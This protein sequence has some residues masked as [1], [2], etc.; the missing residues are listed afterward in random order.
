MSTISQVSDFY[1]DPVQKSQ[2]SHFAA[3]L[4][5]GQINAHTGFADEFFHASEASARVD[6]LPVSISAVLMA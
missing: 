1:A 6:D 4:P 3:S 5:L 2:M